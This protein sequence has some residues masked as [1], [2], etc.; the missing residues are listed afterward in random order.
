M[1]NKPLDLNEVSCFVY[2]ET[3]N[4][5]SLISEGISYNFEG[6][7]AKEIHKLLLSMKTIN[8]QKAGKQLLKG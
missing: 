4:S 3:N 6:N 7:R 2:D 8:E 1:K 5:L